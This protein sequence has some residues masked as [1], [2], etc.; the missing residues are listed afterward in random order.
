MEINWR[1]NYTAGIAPPTTVRS[2]I[3]MAS[4]VTITHAAVAMVLLLMQFGFPARSK[5]VSTDPNICLNLMTEL[6]CCPDWSSKKIVNFKLQPQS[7]PLRVRRPA[8]ALDAEAAQKYERAT[9]LMRALP[10]NHPWN[11]VQQANIHCAYCSGNL[12]QLGLNISLEIHGSWHFFTWHRAYLYFY[13]RILGKLLNDPSFALPFWNWD[14]PSGMSIPAIYRDNSSSLSN[15]TRYPIGLKF[16]DLGGCEGNNT[17]ESLPMQRQCNLQL[18]HRQFIA[19]FNSSSLFYGSP[20]RAGD[21]SFPGG[22]AIESLPH[23]PVHLFT[24]SDMSI[25]TRAAQDPIFF[26][27]HANI[28]RLW[29]IW[30]SIPGN[31]SKVFNNDKDFLEASFLFWD[32]N[33][34]LVRIMV[35]DVIDTAKLGYVYEQV[36][37]QWMNLR[38]V[39][40]E[41]GSEGVAM[42]MGEDDGGKGE[43]RFPLVLSSQVSVNVGRKVGAKGEKLVVS[44]I[45]LDGRDHVWFKV[46]VGRVGGGRVEAGCF[47]HMERRANERINMATKLQIGITQFIEEIG[48]DGDVW[49]VVTLVPKVGGNKVTVGGVSII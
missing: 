32:E 22:G 37:L 40:E 36:P 23:S 14:D 24:S 45:E 42:A 43:V 31:G 9:A 7:S 10:D 29:A 33:K 25:L 1:Q 13:E 5:P 2:L 15:P 27:H 21:N 16:I 49:V 19:G 39:V 20:Y 48:A 6:K 44:D 11:F 26:A 47:I 18:M 12:R 8:H 30:E 28:D 34:Q 4:W 35:R 46:Y 38:T 41:V 17:V 3:I